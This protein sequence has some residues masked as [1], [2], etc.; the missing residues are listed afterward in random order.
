MKKMKVVVCLLSNILLLNAATNAGPVRIEAQGHSFQDFAYDRQRASVSDSVKPGERRLMKGGY[1][2]PID[3]EKEQQVHENVTTILDFAVGINLT[4]ALERKLMSENRKSK[5]KIILITQNEEWAPESNEKRCIEELKEDIDMYKQTLTELEAKFLRKKYYKEYFEALLK[6]RREYH[7]KRKQAEDMLASIVPSRPEEFVEY[8]LEKVER[9]KEDAQVFLRKIKRAEENVLAVAT[10]HLKKWI[11]ISYLLDKAESKQREISKGRRLCDMDAFNKIYFGLL[12]EEQSIVNRT[13]SFKAFTQSLLHATN[14]ESIKKNMETFK[15]KARN[16]KLS[17]DLIPKEFEDNIDEVIGTTSKTI[18]CF[19]ERKRACSSDE[20]A[21]IVLESEDGMLRTKL[22]GINRVKIGGDVNAEE[23]LSLIQLNHEDQPC[24]PNRDTWNINGTCIDP[25][26][27]S[28]ADMT[29]G[30]NILG[31]MHKRDCHCCVG[32][33]KNTVMQKDLE[34]FRDTAEGKCGDIEQSAKS[35]LSGLYVVND[36]W[37]WECRSSPLFCACLLQ[38][39][40]NSAGVV[41]FTSGI[42]SLILERKSGVAVKY[43][44][45]GTVG[46]VP[47]GSPRRRLLASVQWKRGGFC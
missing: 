26:K 9:L 21:E 39:K 23:S 20:E 47:F 28:C 14:D 7:L 3:V 11:S 37:R 40:N 33:K 41:N 32:D 15:E 1:G 16:G 8:I 36:D 29:V 6:T 2:S 22:Y 35:I 18:Q 31:N 17:K 27:Y 45:G 34:N 44:V 38:V 12:Q 43:T 30:A 19:K 42:D 13:K 24:A 4:Q 25:T 46:G 10:P 5:E